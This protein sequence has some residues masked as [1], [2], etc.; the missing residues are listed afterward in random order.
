MPALNHDQ[1]R[2]LI[3]SLC[4]MWDASIRSDSEGRSELDEE[5]VVAIHRT[6]P[7]VDLAIAVFGAVRHGSVS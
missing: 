1:V 2:A 4:E 7:L 6:G 3:E 5:R